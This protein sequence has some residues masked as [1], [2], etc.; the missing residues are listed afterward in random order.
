MVVIIDAP[1][2]LNHLEELS[3]NLAIQLLTSTFH[4]LYFHQHLRPTNPRIYTLGISVY[5][6]N[7]DISRCVV[8]IPKSNSTYLNIVFIICQAFSSL[9]VNLIPRNS[10]LYSSS[11]LTSL[12]ASLGTVNSSDGAKSSVSP[13]KNEPF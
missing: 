2:P 12:D 7:I 3:N 11:E 6:D 5:W 4:S 1:T 10:F 9:L 13:S 8:I